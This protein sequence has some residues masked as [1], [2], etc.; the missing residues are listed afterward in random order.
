[1]RLGGAGPGELVVGRMVLGGVL[2]GGVGVTLW[3]VSRSYFC[4]TLVHP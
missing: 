3:G 4:Y 1:M 2:S